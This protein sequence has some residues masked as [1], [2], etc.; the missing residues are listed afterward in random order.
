[1]EQIRYDDNDFLLRLEFPEFWDAESIAE[2]LV[3]INDTNGNPVV[4]STSATL[5]SGSTLA[6]DVTA[7]SEYFT[8]PALAPS[9]KVGDLLLIGDSDDGPPE[10]VVVH[11][12]DSAL[13]RV[14]GEFELQFNHSSGAPVVGR[15]AE[16]HF[17]VT[18]TDLELNDR[19]VVKWTPDSDDLAVTDPYQISGTEAGMSGFWA[20]FS[21][22][23]PAEYDMARTRDIARFEAH[24]R[25][26]FAE[27]FSTRGMDINRIVDRTRLDS[28]F[29]LFVRYL[30]LG[31]SNAADIPYDRAAAEWVSWFKALAS[32]PIW[33]DADQ[34]GVE[35]V[36]EG[37]VATH[38]IQITARHI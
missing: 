31:S 20:D 12:Y 16:Y 35:D 27:E 8:F 19:V 2:V 23:Y 7:G 9:P 30:I 14:Y 28:G 22:V 17:D 3:E 10:K 25:R 6:N 5:Y 29:A 32:M 15:F 33:Q 37:E 1:M 4:A 38:E 18:A 24:A 13:L 26:R 11:R 36:G 21:S 34:D